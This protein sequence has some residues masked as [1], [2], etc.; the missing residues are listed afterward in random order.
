[1]PALLTRVS[2]VPRIDRG[3]GMVTVFCDAFGL[4]ASAELESE[5]LDK[6]RQTIISYGHALRR[7]NLW[8]RALGE[9]KIS[10][11]ALSIPVAP[12]EIVI[13]I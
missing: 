2:F 10:W 11:K 13:D 12:G 8:E 4:A 3:E 9:S 6:L 1:M 7:K 5:A